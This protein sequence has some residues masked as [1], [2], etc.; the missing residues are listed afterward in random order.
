ML[1]LAEEIDL[2]LLSLMHEIKIS[3]NLNPNKTTLV[4][5]EKKLNLLYSNKQIIK[6]KTFRIRIFKSIS[7]ILLQKNDFIALEK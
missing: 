4:I 3:Q 1:H 6:S 7:R 2:T 5:L